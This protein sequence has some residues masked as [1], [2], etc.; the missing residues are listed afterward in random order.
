VHFCIDGMQI[1]SLV[2]GYHLIDVR[3]SQPPAVNSTR[4]WFPANVSRKVSVVSDLKFWFLLG[5]VFIQACAATPDKD[6]QE[7]LAPLVFPPA[8]DQPRLIFERTVQSSSDIEVADPQ[9]QLRQMLTGE[10]AGGKAMAKPFDVA[11]CQGH[12]FV[13]DTVQRV[14]MVFDAAQKRFFQFGEREPGLLRK[15]LGLATD[16]D[17]NVYVADGTTRRILVFDQDGGFLKALGGQQ[18]FERLSH[19]AVD[20]EGVT[21]Y[22]VDTGGIDTDA[23]QIRV[24]DVES[25]EHLYDIGQRGAQDGQ[26][27][28]PRDIEFGTDGRLYVVDGGNFRVQVLEKDG[29]WVRSIGT[30]GRRYGQFA[31][32]KG[33]AVDPDGNVYVSDAAHGNFQIFDV[34]GQLL[35]FVGSRSERLDRATYML[36]AGIDVDEDGRVYMV[37]QYFRKLDVYRPAALAETD[38]FL[39]AW[40]LE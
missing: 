3:C 12:V 22:A 11:A 8:P 1:F 10:S 35:L 40:T 13:S 24:F 34:Q 39:G 25:G 33:I 2:C 31:R 38:G 16:S 30:L 20:R 19:I 7:T 36:P 4:F 17:C 37:D 18:W 28:L 23:H 6:E 32:P 29:T 26:F 15:P 21:V 5:V 27:N 9:T 14:V